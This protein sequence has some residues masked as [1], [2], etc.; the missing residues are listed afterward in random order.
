MKNASPTYR[1]EMYNR[2]AD[3]VED[4]DSLRGVTSLTEF[5]AKQQLIV[6]FARRACGCWLNGDGFVTLAVWPCWRHLWRD[7]G[8]L[9]VTLALW[10]VMMAMCAV[11]YFVKV[12]W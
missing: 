4:P 8:P 10:G 2:L 9:V 11:I 5:I 3:A 12:S 7:P 6:G 1:Q